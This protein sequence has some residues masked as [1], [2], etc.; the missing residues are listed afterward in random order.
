MGDT[1]A[2]YYFSAT[3]NSLAMT[4]EFAQ[5]LGVPDFTSILGTLILDDPT[6]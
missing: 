3:G 6:N 1:C 2:I 5:K 4:L